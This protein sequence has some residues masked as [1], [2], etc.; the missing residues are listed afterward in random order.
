MGQ[1]THWN[2]DRPT[3]KRENWGAVEIGV[4]GRLGVADNFLLVGIP[5][6]HPAGVGGHISVRLSLSISPP[7]PPR[8]GERR[9]PLWGFRGENKAVKLAQFGGVWGVSP[10][11]S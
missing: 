6:D 11:L 2:P 10:V 7:F 9:S 8:E 4:S 3:R 5:S 1:P